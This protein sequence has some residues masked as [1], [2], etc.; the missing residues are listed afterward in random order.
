MSNP[1]QPEQRDQRRSPTRLER[2]STP[3]LFLL[4]RIPRWLFMVVLAGVLLAGLALENA[5]G[6]VLLLLLA[7]FLA[8]L[9]AIGWHYVSPAGRVIRLVVLVPLVVVG[10]SYFR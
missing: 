9:A 3:W 6:G 4:Q 7:L 2:L 10:L 5:I 1:N 8:W